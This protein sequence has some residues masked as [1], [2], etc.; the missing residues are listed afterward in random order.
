MDGLGI[1]AGADANSSL[2]EPSDAEVRAELARILRSDRFVNA[3]S[4]SRFLGHIVDRALNGKG[5]ELKEYTLGIDVFDCG[6]AF[7]P[8]IRHDRPR[9]GQAAALEA[10]G[11]LR[12]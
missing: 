2:P 12:R 5:T 4:L 8:K 7:D 3:P 11:V 1:I 9:A 10:A 6:E